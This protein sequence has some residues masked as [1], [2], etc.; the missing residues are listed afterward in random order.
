MAD[1]LVAQLFQRRA[2]RERG[3][4]FSPDR[5]AT[6]R[7]LIPQNDLRWPSTC[8]CVF[9]RPP[10]PSSL[11]LVV[12]CL[13]SSRF[14]RTHL[15]SGDQASPAH[16]QEDSTDN[17]PHGTMAVD[18]ETQPTNKFCLFLLYSGDKIA[19]ETARIAGVSSDK[20]VLRVEVA[21]ACRVKIHREPG[22][23][24]HRA[25]RLRHNR[26]VSGE[27]SNLLY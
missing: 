20:G 11:D 16:H 23:Y 7:Q 5:Y 18:S 24:A 6:Y 19:R 25:T 2:G 10:R 8:Q 26:R 17:N 12:T 1:I 9:F 3:S 22:R 21:A 13:R 14:D 4:E 15:S 27:G